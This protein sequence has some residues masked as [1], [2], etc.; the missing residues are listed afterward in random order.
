MTPA[1]SEFRNIIWNLIGFH[2][3]KKQ[4]SATI[5]NEKKFML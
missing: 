2:A 1:I 3:G 5:L 4:N